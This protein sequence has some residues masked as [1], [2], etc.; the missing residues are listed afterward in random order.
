MRNPPNGEE[1]PANERKDRSSNW[2]SLPNH[3]R[4]LS[5]DEINLPNER[6]YLS[7][8][9]KNP[10][11][12]RKDL[13]S[14]LDHLPHDRKGLPEKWEDVFYFYRPYTCKNYSNLPHIGHNPITCAVSEAWPP[15]GGVVFWEHGYGIAG[16]G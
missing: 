13:S 15:P 8:D 3:R 7:S 12:D 6:K 5:N 16:Q 14:E 11:N 1:H 4:D 9:R 2:E 10:S